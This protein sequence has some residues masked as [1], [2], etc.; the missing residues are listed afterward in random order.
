[1]KTRLNSTHR[2]DKLL[3]IPN[4]CVGVVVLEFG[5]SQVEL[6]GSPHQVLIGF[7]EYGSAEF[8]GSIVGV[9]VRVHDGAAT[10]NVRRPFVYIDFHVNPKSFLCLGYP[11]RGRAASSAGANDGDPGRALEVFSNDLFGSEEWDL[12][13][14]LEGERRSEEERVHQ[15]HA[16]SE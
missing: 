10:A 2:D 3:S 13:R 5:Q 12:E 7:D 8:D 16:H 15:Q 4:G 14:E 9:I 1:M 6:L 11:E